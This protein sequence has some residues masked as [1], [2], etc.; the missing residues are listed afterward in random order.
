MTTQIKYHILLILAFLA[1]C[2]PAS[3][4]EKVVT[5]GLKTIVI[6]AGHGG[7]DPG[8]MNPA[9]HLK[10]KDITLSVALRLGNM[11]K[12]KYPE[13]KVIYT[14]DRDVFI[15]LSERAQIANRNN[16]DLFIS[17]HV[18][19]AK[20]KAA[21]GTETF[22]MGTHKSE[23]NMEICKLENSVISLEEDYH[24]T[25]QG[26]DPQSPESYIIFSMLQNTHLNQ[27]LD[28]A[29]YVQNEMKAG[30]IVV[31]RGIKQA[32][33]LVL[34]K[35][36]MPAVLV[37][38]GFISNDTDSRL[39]A[40]KYNHNT[41]ARRIFAAVE[42]YK[43]NLEQNAPDRSSMHKKG[44]E[45]V[46][47]ENDAHPE[48]YFGIQIFVLSKKLKSGSGHFKGLDAHC[49]KINGKYKYIV[50]KFSTREEA[51]QELKTVKRK[52]PEAF[53]AEIKN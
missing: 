35:A 3:A 20:S 1:L 18:N 23:A 13:I 38:L 4:D 2:S 43:E 37:E 51:A 8:A 53:I 50:G 16:A 9:K 19:S 34:W 45:I 36:S 26:F 41:F 32:G 6:D 22:V 40:N 30:P 39:L 24:T 48:P 52:F 12:E 10:E 44:T 25:Y 47:A 28:F 42:K 15:G 27:S 49:V 14:R 31:N 5:A 46:R 11:I 7:K 29:S 33:L 21:R 17:I